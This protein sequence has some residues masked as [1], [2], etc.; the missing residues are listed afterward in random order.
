LET[1]K[2]DNTDPRE[3]LHPSNYLIYTFNN[4]FPRINWNY[5]TTYEIDN[6]IKPLKTKNSYGY[7]EISITIL[8]LSTPQNM[9]AANVRLL[10]E[11]E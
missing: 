2:K 4:T 9:H 3:N 10:A 7:D 11:G 8:K 5:A 6:I 1:S